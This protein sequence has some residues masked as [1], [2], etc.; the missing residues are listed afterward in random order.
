M[1][2]FLFMGT[3]LAVQRPVSYF[4]QTYTRLSLPSSFLIPAQF[5]F[6]DVIL[7]FFSQFFQN[8]S[9]NKPSKWR[10]N[11]PKNKSLNSRK[12]FRSSTKM[13]MAPSRRKNSGLS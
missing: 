7:T 13:V 5:E 9:T 1:G 8:T 11:S 12:R 10:I 2:Q 4:R 3:T 6:K